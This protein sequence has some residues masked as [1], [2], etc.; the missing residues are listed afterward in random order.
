MEQM[1]ISARLERDAHM[2]RRLELAGQVGEL[3]G[4]LKMVAYDLSAGEV[5][6]MVAA[7]LNRHLAEIT[8]KY[9]EVTR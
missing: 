7:L 9:G 4:L 2:R 6:A 5:P 3:Q 1:L 8:A